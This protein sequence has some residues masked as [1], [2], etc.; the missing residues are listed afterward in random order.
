M[1]ELKPTV[2]D[3]RRQTR[4]SIYQFIFKSGDPVTKQQISVSL[5]LSLPTVYQNLSELEEAGLIQ[6]GEIQESTGGRP[7]MGYI[8]VAG[9]KYAIGISIA[10][11]RIRIAAT[12][13]KKNE[14]AYKGVE[15]ESLEPERLMGQL[16]RELDSFMRENALPEDKLLGIGITIPG[17]I[18]EATGTVFL[19]PT[20]KM[21]DFR[22]DQ[23][24]ALKDC[25]ITVSNDS[26]CAGDAEWMERD[27]E[28]K[29]KDFVYLMLEYGVG[30]AIYINGSS[31]YGENRRSAEFGHMCIVPE[32]RLC[33]CGKKGCVEAYCSALR[34]SRDLGISVEE[35]FEKLNDNEEYQT[36]WEDVLLHLAMTIHNLRMAFDCDIVLGG[37]VAE[38]L[39]PYL[40]RLREL[41]AAMNTFEQ[42]GDYLKLGWFPR[43]AGMYGAAWR[44]TSQFISEI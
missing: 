44:F 28:G 40:P 39:E 16:E 24:K 38:Y 20:M 42:N 37:F 32:G 41:T 15:V 31:Y 22:L 11:T 17:V 7:P 35:F 36:L 21:K 5:G 12:D 3:R 29:M 34:F 27:A 33:N 10:A 43:R 23:M 19:S 9:I 4:S 14:L 18:D 6:V 26:T 8:A 1:K 25:P 13:L 2:T 30:G